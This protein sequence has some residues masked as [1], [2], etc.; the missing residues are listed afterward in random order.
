MCNKCNVYITNCSCEKKCNIC[1]EWFSIETDCKCTTDYVASLKTRITSDMSDE[2]DVIAVEDQTDVSA[3]IEDKFDAFSLVPPDIS[4]TVDLTHVG[5]PKT[6]ELVE[7]LITSHKITQH[8][9]KL[10]NLT[11]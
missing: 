6:R 8:Q 5:D 11:Q 10:Q 2:K 9:T 4:T 1:Q 3:I 7:S